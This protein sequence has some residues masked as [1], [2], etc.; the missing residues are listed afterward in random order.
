MTGFFNG[1]FSRFIYIVAGNNITFY[2]YGEIIFHFMAV[3][4]FVDPLVYE[5]MDYFSFGAFM[6][7]CVF[8]ISI[9]VLFR[10]MFSVLWITYLEMEFW[11][12]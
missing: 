9:Q 4:H 7:K 10:F 1:V 12:M 5:Y 11:V 6:H 2:Y 3:P 8:N